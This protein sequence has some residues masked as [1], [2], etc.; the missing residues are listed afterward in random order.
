MFFKFLGVKP[1]SKFYQGASQLDNVGVSG[2]I[3]VSYVAS[4]IPVR[5]VFAACIVC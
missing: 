5:Q 1:G 3:L 4:F 2:A